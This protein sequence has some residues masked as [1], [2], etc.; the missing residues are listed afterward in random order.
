MTG[1][2]SPAVEAQPPPEVTRRPDVTEATAKD[3]A[4]DRATAAKRPD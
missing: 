4:E 3:D 2:I 1:A